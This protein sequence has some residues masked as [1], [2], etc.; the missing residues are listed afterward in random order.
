MVAKKL[1]ADLLGELEECQ[2]SPDIISDMHTNFLCMMEADGWHLSDGV[3]T[4]KSSHV[5]DY[6]EAFKEWCQS[7][8]K[9][10]PVLF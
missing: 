3:F 1:I 5:I 9:L 6:D 4:H 8:M 2:R 10:T 7:E